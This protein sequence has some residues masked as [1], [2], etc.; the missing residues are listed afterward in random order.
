MGC[1][2]NGLSRGAQGRGFNS[3][4][5]LLDL[6]RLTAV[7]WDALWR[8]EAHALIARNGHLALADQVPNY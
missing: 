6:E 4:V 7:R 3:G 5:M 1:S 8:A 2:K